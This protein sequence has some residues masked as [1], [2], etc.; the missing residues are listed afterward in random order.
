MGHHRLTI[1]KSQMTMTHIVPATNASGVASTTAT[2]KAKILNLIVVS[3]TVPEQRANLALDID[4]IHKHAEGISKKGPLDAIALAIHKILGREARLLSYKSRSLN[5]GA[6]AEGRVTIVVFVDGKRRRT[7]SNSTDTN[8]AF[9]RA[10]LG[11][12]NHD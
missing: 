4:G 8:L 11:A 7:N 10:Y 5:E 2:G 1:G 3:G 6:G 12:F 9:A